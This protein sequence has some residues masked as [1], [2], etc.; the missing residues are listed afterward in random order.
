MKTVRSE[1]S[2]REKELLGYLVKY[3]KSTKEEFR[4]SGLIDTPTF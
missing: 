2:E 4:E 1:R 3:C